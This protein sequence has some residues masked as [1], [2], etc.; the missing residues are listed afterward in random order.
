[1]NIPADES[2]MDAMSKVPR[3]DR[4]VNCRIGDKHKKRSLYLGIEQTEWSNTRKKG[5]TPVLP[6]EGGAQT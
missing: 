5:E 3:W 2:L 1:M 6:C 4:T